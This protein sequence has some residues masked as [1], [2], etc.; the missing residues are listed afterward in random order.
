VDSTVQRLQN[1]E[2]EKRVEGCGHGL[3]SGTNLEFIGM[4]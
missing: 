2:L 3:T 1:N 4:P